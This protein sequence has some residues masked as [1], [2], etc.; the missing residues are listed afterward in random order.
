MN[1]NRTI[2]D[3]LARDALTEFMTRRP[4][5][6]TFLTYRHYRMPSFVINEDV[7]GFMLVQSGFEANGGVTFCVVAE[8]DSEVLHVTVAECSERDLF[9]KN[10]AR[11]I[12]FG[13]FFRVG[14]F[15]T[16]P[17][18]R[19]FT[20]AENLEVNWDEFNVRKQAEDMVL[21]VKNCYIED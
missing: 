9:N 6:D 10:I 8:P 13:R 21:S 7:D 2:E 1:S 3:D 17:W 19:N 15:V 20:I 18:D 5:A 14:D 4:D 11:E 12:S 16:I